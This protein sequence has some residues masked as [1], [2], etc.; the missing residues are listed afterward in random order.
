MGK[1]RG[2]VVVD[3]L[4][5]WWSH[6]NESN[7]V[8]WYVFRHFINFRGYISVWKEFPIFLIPSPQFQIFPLPRLPLP[9][10]TCAKPTT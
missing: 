9:P 3:G 8:Y 2:V 5:C 6:G 7:M 4:P 1:R 10:P